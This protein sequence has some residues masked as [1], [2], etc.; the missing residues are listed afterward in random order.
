MPEGV[1]FVGIGIA[2]DEEFELLDGK[3][4][5]GPR[6]TSTAQM[7]VQPADGYLFQPQELFDIRKFEM[8]PGP[9]NQFMA[10]AKVDPSTATI[11]VTAKFAVANKFERDT[12]TGTLAKLKGLPG[13]VSMEG[14]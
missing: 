2:K 6:P 1:K 3:I 4:F 10:V 5:K 11:T 14:A 8:V 13:F 9:A 12:V 7:L